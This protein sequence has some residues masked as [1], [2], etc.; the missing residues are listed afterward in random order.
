MFYETYKTVNRYFVNMYDFH[1][2]SSYM[3]IDN[4]VKYP[5]FGYMV[6]SC[7]VVFT[8][9]GLQKIVKTKILQHKTKLICYTGT[10]VKYAREFRL[11]KGLCYA[12]GSINSLRTLVWLSIRVGQM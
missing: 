11:Y 3:H 5:T 10:L 8:V 9:Y 12:G 2:R 4:P 1:K 6:E 7:A